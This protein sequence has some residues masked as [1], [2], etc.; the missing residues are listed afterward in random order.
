[1]YAYN[2]KQITYIQVTKT[3]KELGCMHIKLNLANYGTEFVPDIVQFLIVSMPQVLLCRFYLKYFKDINHDISKENVTNRTIN[4]LFDKENHSEHLLAVD[5]P[6]S[7]P[8][9]CLYRYQYYMHVC[10]CDCLPKVH[11]QIPYILF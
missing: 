1:M 4:W 3:S 8:N 9:F 6:T 2:I 11:L 7:P 5:I 10:L